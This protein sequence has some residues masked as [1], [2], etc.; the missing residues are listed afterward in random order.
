VPFF[1]LFALHSLPS[2]ALRSLDA[3]P[4]EARESNPDRLLRPDADPRAPAA[5]M[6]AS[7]AI[8]PT[9]FLMS[10]HTTAR[11]MSAETQHAC[12]ETPSPAARA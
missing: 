3:F 10:H 5:A 6:T 8:L 12:K 9:R 7:A 2:V 4:A 11:R 1:V